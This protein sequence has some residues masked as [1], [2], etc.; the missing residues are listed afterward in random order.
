MAIR[1]IQDEGKR[2]QFKQRVYSQANLNILHAFPPL[3]LLRHWK[4]T[5][6]IPILQRANV[7]K[8]IIII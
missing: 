5:L 3:E 6:R 1:K 4:E 8:I 2:L 7:K